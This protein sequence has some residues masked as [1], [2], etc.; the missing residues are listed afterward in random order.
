MIL[1]FYHFTYDDDDPSISPMGAIK[2]KLSRIGKK[3]EIANTR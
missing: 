3:D 2:G 1:G